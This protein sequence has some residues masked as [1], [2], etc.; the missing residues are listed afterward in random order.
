MLFGGG[1]GP[2]SAA[3]GQGTDHGRDKATDHSSLRRGGVGTGEDTE[4][5]LRKKA[6]AVHLQFLPLFDL[7][8][9]L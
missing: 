7:W 3:R 6:E 5:E 9:F 1:G 4:E 2:L 8:P